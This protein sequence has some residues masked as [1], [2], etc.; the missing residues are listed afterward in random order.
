MSFDAVRRSVLDGCALPASA[1]ALPFATRLSLRGGGDV[2]GPVTEAFGV[3]PPARPLGSAAS[4]ERAAL[5]QGPDEW[6][7]IAEAEAGDVEARLE[8]A[9]GNVFHTLV[10][11]SHRQVGLALEGPAAARLL[12]AGCPLDLDLSAF[13]VGMAT[14]TLF[15]KAEIGLW[16]RADTAFRLEVGRS[17]A[18]YVAH[19]L[20]EA[21]RDQGEG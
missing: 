12:A 1:T 19:M 17:F 20:N 9:L 11:I 4:G 5:W 13:P 21:A 15:V 3:A 14:R 8:A 10:N 7:L 6:L 16:R 2:V 18:P